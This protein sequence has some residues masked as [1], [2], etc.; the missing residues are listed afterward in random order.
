[1]KHHHFLSVLAA[2]CLFCTSADASYSDSATILKVQT[3]LSESGLYHSGLDGIYG[4]G[5]QDAIIAYQ[6]QS[7]LTV[8]GLITDELLS[9]LRL[10]PGGLPDLRERR[11]EEYTLGTLD[12]SLYQ[13]RWRDISSVIAPI[14]Y[15]AFL[16][17]DWTLT[18]SPTKDGIYTLI[19]EPDSQTCDGSGGGIDLASFQII[20]YPEEAIGRGMDFLTFIY[21]YYDFDGSYVSDTRINHFTGTGLTTVYPSG[22]KPAQLVL[23]ASAFGHMPEMDYTYLFAG[24]DF[25]GEALVVGFSAHS[26]NPL[27]RRIIGNILSSIH[28]TG[29]SRLRTPLPEPTMA[30]SPTPTPASPQSS[31]PETAESSPPLPEPPLPFGESSTQEEEGIPSPENLF[32]SDSGLLPSDA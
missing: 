13:G 20:Y 12:R 5:T 2:V 8:D 17:S 30:P 18:E 7:A 4:S 26:R 24:R 23:G 11:A 9:S 10:R 15:E 22:E 19:Y 3:A 16:P 21:D 6:Q 14:S 27:T 1:M 29:E 28:R 25:P 32:V 31:I